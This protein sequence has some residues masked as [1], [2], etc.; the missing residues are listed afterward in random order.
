MRCR[1]IQKTLAQLGSIVAD[2][3]RLQRLIGC[4]PTEL[5]D[6]R[7]KDI[8]R[9][10]DIGFTDLLSVLGGWGPCPLDF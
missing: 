1:S 9:N 8:D 10:G 3:V 6:M 7:P 2:M 4:R 5:C